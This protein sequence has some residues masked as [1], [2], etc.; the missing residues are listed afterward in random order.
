VT[1]FT[2]VIPFY[3]GSGFKSRSGKRSGP[4]RQKVPV[5]DG[6]VPK[7]CHFHFLWAVFLIGI[8]M[9]PCNDL[10]LLVQ[11]PVP[12]KLTNTIFYTDPDLIY[13]FAFPLAL[14][15]F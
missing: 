5:S 4:L 9:D 11:D 2:F 12:M 7:N 14:I 13:K 15:Y 3:V 8:R 6:S 1:F 10:A